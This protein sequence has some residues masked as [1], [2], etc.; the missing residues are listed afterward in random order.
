MNV[1]RFQS[2]IDVGV[3]DSNAM[4][5]GRAVKFWFC[6]CCCGTGIELVTKMSGVP[7]GLKSYMPVSRTKPRIRNEVLVPGTNH[8][9]GTIPRVTNFCRSSGVT[10]TG[11]PIGV[12]S[13]T[14]GPS[15]WSRAKYPGGAY[16]STDNGATPNWCDVASS[17]MVLYRSSWS[18]DCTAGAS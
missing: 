16:T 3:Q 10:R 5:L 2:W 17:S 12:N 11:G 8:E 9:P 18:Y 1:W 6:P 4:R 14:P 13:G 15:C 7:I